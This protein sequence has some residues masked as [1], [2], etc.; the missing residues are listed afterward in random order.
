MTR[1]A[2]PTFH[3]RLIVTGIRESSDAREAN[4]TLPT[5]WLGIRPSSEL[6]LNTFPVRTCLFGS[7]SFGLE[8]VRVDPFDCIRLRSANADIKIN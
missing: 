5:T 3:H 2:R 7:V 4:P 1:I 8:V 6:V